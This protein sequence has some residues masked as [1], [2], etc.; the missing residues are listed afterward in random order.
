[1]LILSDTQANPRVQEDPT[2]KQITTLSK[3][4]QKLV[5]NG[6]ITPNL[7]TFLDPVETHCARAYGTPK[8]HK[9]EDHCISDRI[10]NIQVI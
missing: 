8:I 3:T 1:M 4:I 9:E 10:T 6:V 2:K 7:K 5:K